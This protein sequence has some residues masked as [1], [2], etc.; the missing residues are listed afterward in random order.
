MGNNPK[1]TSSTTQT[2]E[3]NRVA[4]A[5]AGVAVG[6]GDEANITFQNNVPDGSLELITDVLKGTESVANRVID[7]A[8]STTQSNAMIAERQKEDE[9]GFNFKDFTP[10]F[11]IA[12]I[13]AS[14]YFYRR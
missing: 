13:A 3:D 14:I 7:L 10:L 11:L 4:A 8:K 12:G 6:V 1:S 5:D 2:T 9:T